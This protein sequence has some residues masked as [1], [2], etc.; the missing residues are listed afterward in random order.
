MVQLRLNEA[1]SP[2]LGAS[3]ILG[4]NFLL[5][6]FDLWVGFSPWLA[7]MR[8]A[9]MRAAHLAFGIVAGPLC[10]SLKSTATEF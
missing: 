1:P 5:I 4:L 6:N 2:A 10:L 9:Q 3:A 7:D 8:S